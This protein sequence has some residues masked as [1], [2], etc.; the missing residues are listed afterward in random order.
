MSEALN[1]VEESVTKVLFDLMTKRVMSERGL[2]VGVQASSTR[3]VQESLSTSGRAGPSRPSDENKTKHGDD[4]VNAKLILTILPTYI[5]PLSGTVNQDNVPI[6]FEY[7]L[8]TVYLPK[9]ICAVRVDQYKIATLKFSDFN[10]E[11]RKVYNM[12]SPQKY[13]TRTKGKN[14]KI[15]PQSW[16]MNLTQSSPLNVMKIPHFRIH[17]KVNACVKLLLYCYHG[18]Y[19]WLNRH[20]TVDLTL[21]NQIMGLS[22]QGPDPQEFYPGKAMDSALA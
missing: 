6:Y 7:A 11:D 3:T 13:L 1:A 16:T 15:I 19:L 17:Q 14:S 22:M 2:S 10:L 20:I 18:G 5:P 12:L 9:G 4:L 8:V 21:I